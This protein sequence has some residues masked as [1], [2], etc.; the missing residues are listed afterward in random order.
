MA[1][2]SV[3]EVLAA[4]A[5]LV[6][7]PVETRARKSAARR[8]AEGS[9]GSGALSASES[10]A[11]SVATFAERASSSA[12]SLVGDDVLGSD[13]AREGGGAAPA[14]SCAAEGSCEVW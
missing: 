3:P 5:S 14:A 11:R 7:R 9:G 1:A 8:C 4:P 10:L 6:T 13:D 12:E 2:V